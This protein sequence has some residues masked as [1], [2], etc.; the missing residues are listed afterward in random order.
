MSCRSANHFELL[1]NITEGFTPTCQVE[2]LSD[3]LGDRQMTRPRHA[4]N[5]AV[6]GIFHNHL[7]SFSHG[8]SLSDSST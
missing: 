8:M 4:L 6:F 3:P 7:Q 5:F 2:C 1:A